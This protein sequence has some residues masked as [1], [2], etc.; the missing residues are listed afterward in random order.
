MA[1]V[2]T[3]STA[4]ANGCRSTSTT[5]EMLGSLALSASIRFRPRQRAMVRTTRMPRSTRTGVLWPRTKSFS[6]VA[7]VRSVWRI[8]CR[9]FS[10]CV[11]RESSFQ[12]GTL[13][14][15]KSCSA[16]SASASFTV[17][18]A[19]AMRIRTVATWFCVVSS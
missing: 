3:R 19:S 12:N 16:W 11:G 8:C 4:V 15:S 5:V 17:A 9:T 2:R 18:S 7:W 6:A 1:A 10:T 13:S 14:T